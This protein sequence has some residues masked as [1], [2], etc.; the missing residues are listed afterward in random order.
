MTPLSLDWDADDEFPISL[1]KVKAQLRIPHD[2]FDDLITDVHLPGAVNWAEGIMRRSILS[3]VHRW[4][5]DEFPNGPIRLPRGKTISIS[6]VA[7][8]SGGSTTTLRGPTSGSP[9]GTQYQEA[10]R[11]NDGGILMPLRN[12]AWPAVDYDVPAP[13]TITF[14][15]GW[16][17]AS[18]PGDIKAAITQYVSDALDI[19]GAGDLGANTNLCAKEIL[20]SS[21]TLTR[22]Y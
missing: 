10:L 12:G 17:T 5:I 22:W 20:L 3:K 1:S 8:V 18:V 19:T 9:I 21:W 13:I 14:T 7:Y 11:G 15:A 2:E 6:S 16:A 4:V